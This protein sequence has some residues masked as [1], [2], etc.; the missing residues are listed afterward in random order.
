MKRFGYIVLALAVIG[1]A[2]GFSWSLKNR[3]HEVL[4][5]KLYGHV[6]FRQIELS[7][8][9]SERI[10]TVM[11]E[12]GASV[13]QGQVLARLDVRRLEPKVKEALA[14]VEAL[15]QVVKRLRNGSRPEEIA[16]A[17][18]NVEAAEAQV[19]NARMHYERVEG[20]VKTDDAANIEYGDMKTALDVMEARLVAARK[21][22]ELVLAGPRSEEIAEAEARLQVAEAQL[23]MAQQQLADAQLIAPV[24]AVVRSRLLEPGEIAFPQRPVFSLAV[25]DPKWVRAYVC[26]PDLGKVGHGMAVSIEV[27]SY[28]G[29]RFDAW[30]GF[31]SPVAEFTPKSVQVEE[32]RTSLVYE[33]RVFVKDPHDELRLGMPTTVYL[34]VGRHDVPSASNQ[35]PGKTEKPIRT[36]EGTPP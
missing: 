12:E 11:V 18:A 32:L 10:E 36:T 21:T 14:Q 19:V 25:S 2:A 13:K 33:V 27:D 4:E 24:D 5:S 3:G 29:R 34:P 7:F 35:P 16:Q 17:R 15:R 30:V 1:G 8:N 28:P 9:L 31:I 6:D 20:L 22:L 23:A 26:A